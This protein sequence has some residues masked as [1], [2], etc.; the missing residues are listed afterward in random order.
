MR[1]CLEENIKYWSKSSKKD[2]QV[3][4]DLFKLKY[5]SQCLFFCHLS[6]EKLLKGM[7]V[8][9]IN[10]FA[11]YTHDLQ[12]LAEIAGI[13]LDSEQE[14]ILEVISTFNVAG[15]YPRAK[16]EFYKTYNNTGRAQK[17]LETTDNLLKWLKKEFRKKSK[18]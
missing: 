10:D 5:Y 4:R 8:E 12:R 6:V 16:L 1:K 18:T 11:P 13:S 7:V 15:R 17:Y 2:F 9:K 14:Q 3:A